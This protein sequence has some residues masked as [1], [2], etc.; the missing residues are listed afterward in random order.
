MNTVPLES[1]D[2]KHFGETIWIV[3]CGPSLCNWSKQYFMGYLCI[4]VNTAAHYVNGITAGCDNFYRVIFDKSSLLDYFKL[5]YYRSIW[6]KIPPVHSFMPEHIYEKLSDDERA[7]AGGTS[8]SMFHSQGFDPFK[9]PLTGKHLFYPT[10]FSAMSLALRMGA[11]MLKLVGIDYGPVDGATHWDRQWCPERVTAVGQ[12]QRREMDE[13][14]LSVC[15]EY[16]AMV[17]RWRSPA[18]RHED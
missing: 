2:G 8:W 12:Y 11:S 9:Y 6:Q 5:P 1:F 14:M 7:F 13:Q 4:F 18:E 17:E 15:K 10:L 3:G 16:G